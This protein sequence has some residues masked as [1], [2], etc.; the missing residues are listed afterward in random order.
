MSKSE[1]RTER[2]RSRPRDYRWDELIALMTSFEYTW[3]Q[4]GSSHGYFLNVRT[5]HKIGIARPHNHI[6]KAYQISDILT[7]L[8]DEG[9]I[10]GE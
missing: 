5:R 8:Q 2:L 1:K 10:E 6:L 9:H 3:V 7:S 4:A